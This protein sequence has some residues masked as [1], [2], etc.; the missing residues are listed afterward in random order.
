MKARELKPAPQM[1]TML[2]R[3][4]LVVFIILFIPI[5][6]SIFFYPVISIPAIF[7]W[8]A[9]VIIND[10][11]I[12]AMFRNLS[13]SLDSDAMLLN[14]GVFWKRRTTV[15]Y[16][17]ITNIDITQ[18]P[19][20]RAFGLSKIHIQTA[21]LSGSENTHA[22]LVMRGVTDPEELKAEIMSHILKP[23][24]AQV[25]F[26]EPK[27]GSADVLQSILAELKAIR[28]SVQK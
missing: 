25:A 4:N 28:Q 13:Y 3:I 8:L 5:L 12:M 14:K 24:G 7:I 22:E 16:G 9:L 10:A 15:P 26:A 27:T 17:K 20:E 6:A 21:G 11:Y 1:R 2:R 18:G 19:V 23:A